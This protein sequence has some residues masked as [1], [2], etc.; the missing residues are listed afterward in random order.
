MTAPD[1]GTGLDATLR[2]STI[3]VQ[4]GGSASVELHIGGFGGT[5]DALRFEVLGEAAAWSFVIPPTAPEAASG[6]MSARLVVRPSRA[7]LPAAGDFPISVRVWMEEGSGEA[8][9]KGIVT[10]EP[11]ADVLVS[12]EPRVGKGRSVS[13]HELTVENRGNAPASVSFR[14]DQGESL[15]IQVREEALV[16]APGRPATTSVVVRPDKRFLRGAV[17]V[18]PFQV[19]VTPDGGAALGA[20]GEMHQQ[21]LF[22]GKA[23][24]GAI[25][26]I[27]I[28]LLA[29]V[30][31]NLGSSS[32]RDAS[33]D[34]SAGSAVLA[35]TSGCPGEG[36]RDTYASGLT[37]D[38]IP[39]LPAGYSFTFVKEDGCT[40]V[41]FDPCQ[42]VHYIM[43]P[44][45][46]PPTGVADVDEGFKRLA[47]VTGMT[48]VNDGFTD[49][50][51]RRDPYVPDRYPNRWAPILIVWTQQSGDRAN[52]E[53]VG[54]GVPYRVEDALVSGTLRLYA[55]AVTNRARNTP[56]PGGFGS[57]PGFGAIGAEGVTWGRVILHEL[58]HVMGL[59][60][61]RDRDQLMYPDTAEQTSHTTDYRSGDREGLRLL[62]RASGCLPST[63]PPG[64]LP[65]PG[66]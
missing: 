64:P 48:F 65:A 59:G 57:V 19:A 22:A 40:P 44:A 18:H 51:T 52:I 46:A 15:S 7:A 35:P 27:V 5:A 58:A 36:H 8:I 47:Q 61:T 37:P 55:D 16:I 14:V 60:H 6:E 34:A 4:P 62:G 43:N 50:V 12:L 17:R 31:V 30:L 20:R 63:P 2:P 11:V 3:S 13:R 38:R 23:A 9:A 41:R 54:S 42:P 32:G 56:V 24:V 26:A 10:V 1:A 28:A 21:P 33:E 29:I 53:V 45:Q 49:E 39:S 66:P 25:V